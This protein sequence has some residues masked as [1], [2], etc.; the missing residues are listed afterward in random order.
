MPLSAFKAA[1][2]FSPSKLHEMR[3]SIA[4]IDSLRSFPFLSGAI[5]DLR[6]KFPQY[7]A[8]VEDINSSY[9]P[10]FFWKQHEQKLPAWVVLHDKCS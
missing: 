8:A 6:E 1:R 9:D 3:P 4:T 10:L 2:L 5:P 7:V